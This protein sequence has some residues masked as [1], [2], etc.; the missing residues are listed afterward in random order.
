VEVEGV[1]Q[2][3]WADLDFRPSSQK[4]YGVG[5]DRHS[6]AYDGERIKLWHAGEIN[7]FGRK[8]HAGDVLGCC[9]DLDVGKNT[10][11]FSHNGSFE[12]PMGDAFMNISFSGGI[13]PALCA[14][15]P[16]SIKFN[17]GPKFDFAPPKGFRPIS[18][19]ISLHQ[20][21]SDLN[22]LLKALDDT[23]EQSIMVPQELST[24]NSNEIPE[25]S[26]PLPLA[27]T[28]I[29]PLAVQSGLAEAVIG[30]A[31]NSVI[32]RFNYPTVIANHCH[33]KQGCWYF[34]VSLQ[35]TPPVFR[36]SDADLAKQ[37]RP[38]RF[39]VGVVGNGFFGNSVGF[40]GIGDDSL[41][42]ALDNPGRTG[43]N[44]KW[45]YPP[46]KP[47]LQFTWDDSTVHGWG[48]IGCALDCGNRT[49]TYYG[50]EEELDKETEKEL[51]EREKAKNKLRE[52]EPENE[53]AKEMTPDKEE[54]QPE[55]KKE[56]E[57]PKSNKPQYALPIVTETLSPD[58]KWFTPA[59][60][61]LT[62]T[63]V[64]INFGENPFKLVVPKGCESVH[65]WFLQNKN[66]L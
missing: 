64:H 52:H 15:T 24:Q 2:V 19:L 11:S 41:S 63:K 34:E 8:W 27:N 54:L 40:S 31:D 43:N 20:A 3:G 25:S 10:L 30:H 61:F 59:V 48:V 35:P 5:D 47:T 45:K 66:K 7:G 32:A 65:H 60:S 28:P 50:L 1:A 49:I 46:R 12:K 23:E 51:L 62:G 22:T 21:D 44:G 57:K 13:R 9:A 58:V 38:N 16:F 36:Q 37:P 26:I 4:G 18:D 55:A 29:L 56:E 14:S 39:A 53:K 6:W 42:W 33:L 17:F